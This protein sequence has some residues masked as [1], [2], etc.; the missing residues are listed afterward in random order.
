MLNKRYL[1]LSFFF[2]I[3]VSITPALYAQIP[4]TPDNLKNTPLFSATDISPTSFVSP[5]KPG[6]EHVFVVYNTNSSYGDSIASYY[7]AA[8]QIPQSNICAIACDTVEVIT[9]DYYNTYIRD[10]LRDSLI[11]RGIK[12]QIRFIVLAKGIPLKISGEDMSSVDSELCL[13]FNDEY[14]F[15][16][17]ADNAYFG[18]IHYFNSFTYPPYSSSKMSYLVSRLDAFTLTDVLAMIDRGV[19]PD[20]SGTGWYILD[21]HPGLTYDKMFEAKRVLDELVQNSVYDNTSTHITQ[22]DQGD[23]M[24]YCG[25]G[26]HADAGYPFI[27]NDLNFNFANGAL[28]N[29]YESF[30]G[31]SFFPEGRISNHNLI[32]DFI[33]IGGTGGIG[34]VYEPYSSAIPHENILFARY[35]SGFTLI[36]AAY[37][38]MA[39][40]S[41]R[42]VV[43]GDPLCRLKSEIPVYDDA[44][45]TKITIGDIV[46]DGGNS[47]ASAWGDY[48]ND[49]YQDLFVTNYGEPNFL[50]RNNGNG[51]LHEDYKWS[52]WY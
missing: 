48:D 2:L 19:N 44:P 7:Q 13:L 45:F 25:H 20:T 47:T 16:S 27:L 11:Q 23:V 50:Y 30:N 3:T 51:N 38:S 14:S 22:N 9:R 29:T 6:T 17:R 37:M 28:F 4:D 10:V 49:G 43:V 18:E 31:Y 41:W 42:N 24:G 39:Y 34:H 26:V 12:E 5:T 46:N 40:I 35:A 15:N 36:E 32:A 21:D 33:A 1:L 8:R 52:N